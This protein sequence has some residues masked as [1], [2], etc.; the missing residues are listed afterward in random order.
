MPLPCLLPAV[1]LVAYH[2]FRLLLLVGQPG[3]QQSQAG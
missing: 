3:R 2:C 1:V